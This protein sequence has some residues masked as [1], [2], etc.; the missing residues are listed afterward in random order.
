V[1]RVLVV[2]AAVLVALAGSIGLIAF[3]QSRDDAGIGGAS[4]TDAPG[5][6]AP[7]E[8]DDRLRKG[9]VVITY[10]DQADGPALRALAEDV[11]G[12]P[13]MTLVDAGQAVVV[14]QNPDQDEPVVI[15]AYKRRLVA[16]SGADREVREFVEYWLGQ[17]AVE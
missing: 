16:Q 12:P 7:S 3:F 4:N 2:A 1:S 8:T 11:A 9:N 6:T 15:R 17:P 13:D 5:Q 14:E 10:S